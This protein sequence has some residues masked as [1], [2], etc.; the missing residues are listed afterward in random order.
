MVMLTPPISIY[1]Y[2]SAALRGVLN[3]IC[4]HPVGCIWPALL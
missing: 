4:G 2:I 1:V 3:E